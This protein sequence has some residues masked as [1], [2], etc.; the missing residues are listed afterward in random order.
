[1]FVP[2]ARRQGAEFWCEKTPRN[3]LY[4][5]TIAGILPY[6]KFLHVVRDGR[7]V[8]SSI[9]A[10]QFWPVAGSARYP[11]TERFFGDQNF[12]KVVPYWTT[13]IDIARLQEERV[14]DN[15]WC[16]G[17]SGNRGR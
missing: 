7:D 4:A 14:G 9:M 11:E 6:A 10:R 8:A 1:V 17:V 12:E 2:A 16:V 15:G 5:D 3:L 13:L